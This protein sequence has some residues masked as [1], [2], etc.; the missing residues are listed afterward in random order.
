MG[1]ILLKGE[2]GECVQYIEWVSKSF[3]HTVLLF[4]VC[5]VNYMKK[6][7]VFLPFTNSHNQHLHVTITNE[8]FSLLS[9]IHENV[10]DLQHLHMYW[11]YVF[12]SL[13]QKDHLYSSTLLLE[14]HNLENNI[15]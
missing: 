9:L 10:N 8:R 4:L 12:R 6:K 15:K 11:I 2:S 1:L 7:N 3:L 5:V 14:V 13:A